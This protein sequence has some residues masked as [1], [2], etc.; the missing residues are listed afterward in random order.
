MPALTKT[1]LLTPGPTDVPPTVLLEM[2]QPIFHHRTKKFQEIYADLS[3]RLQRVF[4][5]AEP[6]L[7]I[8]GSGTTAFEAAQI[9]LVKP[10]SKVLT[11]AGG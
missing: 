7:T 1:R 5:T 8:A 10:G 11:I 2:A 3:A 6:V 4:R 9:N